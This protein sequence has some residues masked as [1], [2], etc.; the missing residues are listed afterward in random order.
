V[1]KGFP[2]LSPYS[3]RQDLP[4]IFG[5][6]LHCSIAITRAVLLPAR[7][8]PAAHPQRFPPQLPMVN[9]VRHLLAGCFG[10]RRD[11]F[12]QAVGRP[13]ANALFQKRA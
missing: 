3:A 6:P 1:R 12:D 4:S 13:G 2:K 7:G 11:E 10:K 9:K 8:A 5:P